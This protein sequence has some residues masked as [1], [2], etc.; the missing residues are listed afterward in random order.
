[1]RLSSRRVFAIACA[2][3]LGA[4]SAGFA[5]AP[6]DPCNIQTTERVVAI[7]DVHGAYDPFVA[8]L[9]ATGLT[10]G[11]G[12]WTGGRAILVQTGDVVDRGPDSRRVLD[13]LRR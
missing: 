5:Q 7:G 4:A 10:D 11:R 8:L 13:L 12:R 6:S 3:L 9:R 1:M 2:A